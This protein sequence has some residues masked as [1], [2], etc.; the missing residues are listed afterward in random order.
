MP[1]YEYKCTTCDGV[2]ERI[3]PLRDRTNTNECPDCST[4][5]AEFII[6]APQIKLEGITGDFPTAYDRWNKRHKNSPKT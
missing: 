2:S 4:K 5:T 1:M 6:S 3:V